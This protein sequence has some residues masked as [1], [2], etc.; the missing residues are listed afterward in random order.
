[1][2]CFKIPKQSAYTPSVAGGKAVPWRDRKGK[3]ILA[4]KTKPRTAR[5]A[6]VASAYATVGDLG[7]IEGRLRFP[8]HILASFHSWRRGCPRLEHVGRDQSRTLRPLKPLPP[9]LPPSCR[10]KHVVWCWFDV[11]SLS[12]HLA[13][14][15][16]PAVS[17]RITGLGKANENERKCNIHR[18]TDPLLRSLAHTH[19]LSQFF[20]VYAPSS[21]THKPVTNFFQ[22]RQRDFR[23]W[24]CG[25]FPRALKK[26][27]NFPHV[28]RKQRVNA[29]PFP[30]R[31]W[32]KM[33]ECRLGNSSKRKKKT[34]HP[35]GTRWAGRWLK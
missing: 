26:N 30:Q 32:I 12:L 10:R 5:G 33:C 29:S 8:C 18:H 25:G 2:F 14:T 27:I 1:M 28:P 20:R 9:S 15:P 4:W 16:I 34:A 6:P 24:A 21:H 13:T 35:T 23:P 11:V 17:V 7:W 3:A 19:S 31:A 22:T